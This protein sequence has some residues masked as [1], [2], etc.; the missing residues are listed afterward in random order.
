MAW[1]A[2]DVTS[3]AINT[4]NYC[5]SRRTYAL[6]AATPAS[7]AMLFHLL[8][9]AADRETLWVAPPVC[10]NRRIGRT[11]AVRAGVA[12]GLLTPRQTAREICVGIVFM[13][14]CS[15]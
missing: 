4:W 10:V 12:C 13:A 15:G 8:E 6:S 11:I 9:V 7:N 3:S 1:I 5:I 2:H 14:G